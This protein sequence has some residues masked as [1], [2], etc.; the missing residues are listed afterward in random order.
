MGTSS[1][2]IQEF[3]VQ[4]SIDRRSADEFCPTSIFCR[5]VI[6]IFCID[7]RSFPLPI[8]S[9]R[10]RNTHSLHNHNMEPLL[11]DAVQ[12][13]S[14]D[15]EI[16]TF[17]SL[18]LPKSLADACKEMGF[19]YPTKIQKEAIPWALK[20]NHLSNRITEN[21]FYFSTQSKQNNVCFPK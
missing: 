10:T 4:R 17:E 9:H 7:L 1:E 21:L 18:G 19:K 15:K 20:G 16:V 3:I 2:I 12:E 6:C 13:E 14:P 8:R 11:E 5:P